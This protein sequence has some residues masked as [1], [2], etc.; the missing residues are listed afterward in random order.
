[1]FGIAAI[2]RVPWTLSRRDILL[3]A[4][5]GIANQAVYLGLGYVGIA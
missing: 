5:L 1:M 2:S 4:L 3:F